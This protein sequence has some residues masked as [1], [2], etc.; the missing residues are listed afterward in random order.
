MELRPLRYLIA[1]V[2]SGSVTAASRAVHIAQPSLSRQLRQLEAELGLELFDRAGGRLVLTPA[3]E[4]FVPIAR[5]LL[6]RAEAA[7]AAAAALAAGRL[8]R[9]TIAAPPTTM[10]DVIAPFLATLN[11]DDP[12]PSV[13]EQEPQTVYE[14]LRRG[15]DLAISTEPPPRRYAS[16]VL[17]VLPV[18]LY[19]PAAH[20][21]AGRDSVELDELIETTLLVLPP[22]F[23]PRQLLDQAAE[24]S[25][26]RLSRTVENSSAEVAQ[27]LTA[28]GRG[29]AVVTD[30][31]RFDLV[32]LQIRGA[33]G[34]LRVQLHAGWDA[35]HHA[36]DSL[37]ALAGR[38]GAF[39][40]HR[41]G[42]TVAPG[43]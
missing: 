12:F 28:A 25:G 29:L 34:P 32:G 10:T 19:V 33:E 11:A 1:V 26:I 2:D 36:A 5:D 23:K 40:L 37:R 4:Q 20:P 21:W 41:Y 16:L 14:A 35:E 7:N 15:A 18:W 3:G 17:A 22:G 8:D 42:L 24:R 27:A 30:D 6:A 38:V 39:C 13:L 43:G 9:V 31:S